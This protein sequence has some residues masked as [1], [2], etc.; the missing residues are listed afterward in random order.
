LKK[1]RQEFNEIAYMILQ[2]VNRFL[3]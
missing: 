3:T 2:T 1:L